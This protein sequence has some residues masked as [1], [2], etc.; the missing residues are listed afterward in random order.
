MIDDLIRDGWAYHDTESERLAT[1]L[2]AAN[3]D[4][5]TGDMPG[6]CLRLSNHTIGEHLADW[7]RA[8]RFAEAVWLAQKHQSPG[9]AFSANLAVA[10]FMDGAE[11]LAQQAEIDALQKADDQLA[12]YLTVKSLIA[13]ALAGSRRFSDAGLVI[14]AA[15]HLAMDLNASEAANRS[16]AVANN[17]LAS[18]LVESL[19]LDANGVRLMLDCAEAAQTFWNRCGTW[20]NEERALY[21]LALVHNR[22][23]DHRLGLEH[24]L[25]ALDVIAENGE[26]PVDEAFIHL[27]ASVAY[28]GLD[29]LTSA[30]EQLAKADALV[31]SWSDES[32]VS[33]Y[34]DER[35]KVT[36][37]MRETNA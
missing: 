21:L 15:N 12:A 37:E 18:D 14:V 28:S 10:R 36:A 23:G 34:Q 4:E 25:A 3:F 9:E 32:L 29:E 27:A 26:E 19:E 16:M 31:E 11:A 13:G 7:P 2:E 5:L 17:N 6:Q 20:V 22:S 30:T 8:R 24:A 33:W 35:A 1:E